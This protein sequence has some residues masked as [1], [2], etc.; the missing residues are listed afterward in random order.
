MTKLAE[1][2]PTDTWTFNGAAWSV[3]D[4]PGPPPRTAAVMA[5]VG[6]ALVLFGGLSETSYPLGDTWTFDGTTWTA[7]SHPGPPA[8]VTAQAA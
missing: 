8:R 6:N 3:L 1:L 2:V 4:V 7:L 5:P